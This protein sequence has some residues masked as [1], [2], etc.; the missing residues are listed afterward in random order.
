MAKHKSFTR[1][2]TEPTESSMRYFTEND[3]KGSI[4]HTHELG[5]RRYLTKHKNWDKEAHSRVSTSL[6]I[7]MKM[8][9]PCLRILNPHISYLDVRKTSK[10]KQTGKHRWESENTTTK[11]RVLPK[12]NRCTNTMMILSTRSNQINSLANKPPREFG[13]STNWPNAWRSIILSDNDLSPQSILF[14]QKTPNPFGQKSIITTTKV[15]NTKATHQ[16]WTLSG[17]PIQIMHANITTRAFQEEK[18][19]HL[20]NLLITSEGAWYRDK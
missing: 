9:I 20:S 17:F 19:L 5:E 2:S 15:S 13:R 10:A 14:V 6:K 3:D 7:T 18:T 1:G 4:I 16:F 11:P 12:R 8:Q